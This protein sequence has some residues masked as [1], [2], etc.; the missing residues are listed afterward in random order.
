MEPKDVHV[1]INPPLGACEI[2]EVY[3]QLDEDFRAKVI[4]FII[5]CK[6]M[7]DMRNANKKFTN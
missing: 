6:L 2:C 1:N 3:Y 7:Q 5:H 4:N